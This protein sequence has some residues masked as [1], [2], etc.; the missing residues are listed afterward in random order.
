MK[1]HD[2]FGKSRLEMQYQNAEAIQNMEGDAHTSYNSLESPKCIVHGENNE[3]SE[4]SEY[5]SRKECVPR[6]DMN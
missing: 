6:L 2:R 3:F 1:P 4:Y 5:L